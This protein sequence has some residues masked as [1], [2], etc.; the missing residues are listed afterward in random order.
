MLKQFELTQIGQV[1]PEEDETLFELRKDRQS[2][3]E[4][5]AGRINIFKKLGVDVAVPDRIQ[6]A[7]DVFSNGVTRLF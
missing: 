2:L 3:V 4:R 7:N 1:A 6:K 5:L